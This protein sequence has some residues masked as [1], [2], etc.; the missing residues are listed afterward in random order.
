MTIEHAELVGVDGR[1]NNVFYPGMEFD[2]ASPT[3]SMADWYEHKWYECANQTDA[4]ILRLPAAAKDDADTP[5]SRTYTPTFTYHGY[6]FAAVAV[7]EVLPGGGARALPV[8]SWPIAVTAEA[9]RASTDLS[10]L[11]TELRMGVGGSLLQSI[12]D[13]TL[14]S[15]VAQL[16]SIPTDCPQREKRGWMGDAGVSAASL[17]TSTTH[18]PSTPTSSSSST[19]SSRGATT[20]PR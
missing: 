2:H 9:H 7:A 16:W 15:H 19:R 4:L 18:T 10:Q 3:C 17:L 5:W 20:S 1:L 8:S 12:F 11:W 13:A 6:R 14:G